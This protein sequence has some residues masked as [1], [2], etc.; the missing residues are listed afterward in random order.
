MTERS[1][2]LVFYRIDFVSFEE[3]QVLPWFSKAEQLI[4][5]IQELINN[6]AN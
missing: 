6:E 1:R 4:G 2:D 3:S 5:H